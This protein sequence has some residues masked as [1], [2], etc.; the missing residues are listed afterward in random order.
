AYLVSDAPRLALHDFDEALRQDPA[1]GEAHSGRGLALVLLGD[2]RAALVEAEESLRHDP[3][4]ARR[5]YNA[6]RIYAKAA[7]AAGAAIDE[8]GRLAVATVERY[9]DRAV[10]LVRLAL[11]RTPAE[12]R[13]T[14][15]QS[16][17]A[18]DPVL[19]TLQ[20]RLRLLQP[21]GAANSLVT[22]RNSFSVSGIR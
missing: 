17:V 11:E 16:Q 14:F 4:S 10:A 15:W 1:S 20:R 22:D 13:A 12:R 9:Q 6:A 19:R 5:A 7:I 3:A 2:Y 18:T 21:A 8:K